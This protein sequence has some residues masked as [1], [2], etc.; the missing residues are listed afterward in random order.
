MKHH[1]HAH[2]IVVCVIMIY[3][4][5]WFGEIEFVILL[6]PMFLRTV[7]SK[8]GPYFEVGSDK[9]SHKDMPSTTLRWTIA[10]ED[11]KLNTY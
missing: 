6:V 7:W 9:D 1:A 11:I 10:Y 4:S 5:L 2:E 8:I 3:T